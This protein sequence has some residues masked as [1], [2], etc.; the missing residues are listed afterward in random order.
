MILCAD[1]R[2]LVMLQLLGTY[3]VLVRACSISA[4][5]L[6]S[7]S[8]VPPFRSCA[9]L[10][11][12]VVAVWLSVPPCG[13]RVAV[14]V[15]VL[16]CDSCVAVPVPSCGSRVAM[17]VPPCGSCVAVLCPRVVAM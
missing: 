3:Y 8:C 9:M 14:P 16:L 11:P 17:P 6:P 13:S 5:V 4:A 2:T 7:G 1:I 12:R 15:P 10:C